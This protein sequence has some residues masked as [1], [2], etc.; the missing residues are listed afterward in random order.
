MIRICI[1]ALA[2]AL[3]GCVAGQSIRLR[4]EPAATGATAASV[5]VAVTVI[6]HREYVTG[7]DKQPW[8][9]GHYRAGFGNTWDVATQGKVPLAEQLQADLRGELASL[10]LREG[11]G[12]RA[13]A[14]K[15]HEWNFDT[16]MNGRV[17]YDVEATVTGADG[18]P[19]A[20]VRVKDERTVEGNVWTGAKGAMEAQVPAIYGEMIRKL[21][22]ENPAMLAALRG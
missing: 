20:T 18:A 17:W 8:Y 16:L 13:L 9:L 7:G 1:L 15:I 21:V 6:E 22:R 5:P 14:V 12:G 2:L 4:Y 3:A 19:L 10:G 11:S